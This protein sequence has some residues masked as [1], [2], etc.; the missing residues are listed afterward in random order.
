VTVAR[1]SRETLSTPAVPSTSCTAR[2]IG[3]VTYRSTDRGELPGQDAVIRTSG[4]S[5][6]GFHSSGTCVAI[7]APPTR[8]ATAHART[9]VGRATQPA[10][11]EE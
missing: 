10:S 7:Q 6:V 1:P 8:S 3:A 11:Q 4:S 9:D 5:T 2:S